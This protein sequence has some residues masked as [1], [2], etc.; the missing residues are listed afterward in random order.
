MVKTGEGGKC[1]ITAERTGPAMPVTAVDATKRRSA[2]NRSAESL[3]GK[4][5][6]RM[7]A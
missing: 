1:S 5:G 4:H 6:E 3:H 2:L 7:E